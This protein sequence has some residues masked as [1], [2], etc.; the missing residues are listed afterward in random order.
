MASSF[1][2]Y[3]YSQFSRVWVLTK[4][5]HQR[6]AVLTKCAVV[7]ITKRLIGRMPIWPYI[8][9]QCLVLHHLQRDLGELAKD[10]E[11]L[12]VTIDPVQRMVETHVPN[13]VLTP[14]A[15][16]Q[17]IMVTCWLQDIAPY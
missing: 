5:A 16:I 1:T 10:V 11:C 7:C 8:L 6:R 2:I 3:W 12:V 17:S 15:L 4:R 14:V 9:W 13:R